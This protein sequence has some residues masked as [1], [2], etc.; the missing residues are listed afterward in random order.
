M[1]LSMNPHKI[2]RLR[3][4]NSR[5]WFRNALNLC[6]SRMIP[7][8][9]IYKK[10]CLSCDMREISF[11]FKTKW[12]SCILRWVGTAQKFDLVFGSKFTL[13]WYKCFGHMFQGFSIWYQYKRCFVS[14]IVM[15]C[16][17]QSCGHAIQHHKWGIVMRSCPVLCCLGVKK[18]NSWRVPSLLLWWSIRENV[19]ARKRKEWSCFACLTNVQFRKHCNEE[20][21]GCPDRILSI[22]GRWGCLVL[23]SLEAPEIATLNSAV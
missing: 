5:K 3:A 2:F 18:S 1:D 13:H 7:T 19:F 21:C 14:C 22:F 23:I 12:S 4:P 20:R 9:A 11:W 15:Q 10:R 16:V 17:V 8:I 6:A